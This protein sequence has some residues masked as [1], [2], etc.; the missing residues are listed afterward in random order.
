MTWL[1]WATVRVG[2]MRSPRW[3]HFAEVYASTLLPRQARIWLV[4]DEIGLPQ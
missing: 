2:S 1:P 3:A 4:C